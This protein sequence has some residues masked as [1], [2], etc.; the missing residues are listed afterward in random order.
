MSENGQARYPAGAPCWVEL[1]TAHPRRSAAFYGELLGWRCERTGPGPYLTARL[2]GRDGDVAGVGAL[3]SVPPESDRWTTYVCVE[4]ADAAVER[5]RSA[6]GTVLEGPEDVQ[7]WARV[8][9]CADPTGALFGLW[10]PRGSGGAHL[11]HAP[12]AWNF[13]NLTTSD[14]ETVLAFYGEV[15]GWRT[16]VAAPEGGDEETRSI[17]LPG[18]GSFLEESAPDA[19]ERRTRQGASGELADVVARLSVVSAETLAETTPQWGVDF[20]VEDVEA[21]LSRVAQLGGTVVTPVADG[22]GTRFGAFQDPSGTVMALNE[23]HSP[24]T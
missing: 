9:L 15:F 22:E 2:S 12:G 24:P 20:T 5:V 13:S 23:V 17:H 10:E 1:T 11:L 7:G 14:P 4:E 16:R 3:G 8:A 21:V 6:G 19:L 18:Y